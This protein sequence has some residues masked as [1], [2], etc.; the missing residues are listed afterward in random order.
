MD[1]GMAMLR[2]HID[3]MQEYGVSLED[4]IRDVD[5]LAQPIDHLGYLV[6]LL[7]SVA[8]ANPD[9]RLPF[10]QMYP[11]CRFSR[12]QLIKWK[13]HMLV[14]RSANVL[15]R[16][17]HLLDCSLL[18][19]VRIC[20]ETVFNLDKIP[21]EDIAARV[22][23]L[24][25]LGIGTEDLVSAPRL[26]T[27]PSPML[28]YYTQQRQQARSYAQ[29]GG[30]TVSDPA[31][32]DSVDCDDKPA[33]ITHLLNNLAYKKR[34]AK[35]FGNPDADEGRQL[36]SNQ[37]REQ[38]LEGVDNSAPSSPPEIPVSTA[39]AHRQLPLN[40]L[41]ADVFQFIA[42][43]YGVDRKLIA[44]RFTGNNEVHSIT[45]ARFEAVTELL[46]STGYTATDLLV[47]L[48]CVYRY[49]VS[50]VR[51][52]LASMAQLDE[53]PSLHVINV[54]QRNFDRY[55]E[56]AHQRQQKRRRANQSSVRDETLSSG[57]TTGE[58]T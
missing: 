13:K 48:P 3:F 52:R 50:R 7:D 45:L 35:W 9:L 22:A 42:D 15:T 28:H 54:S 49:D 26:L 46:I 53:L 32:S 21:L 34:F 33:L 57:S 55:M 1:V 16:L 2:V 4:L 30:A 17:Q 39:D 43:R 12:G 20:S 19:V 44:Q 6:K 38:K 40:M 25:A 11:M 5:V 31:G 58:M 29:I 37:P 14:H 24:G 47:A 27:L 51:Q 8:E 36:V 56:L 23:A 41:Y 10:S 18:T